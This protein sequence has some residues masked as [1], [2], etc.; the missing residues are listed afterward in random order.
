[1]RSG[2]TTPFFSFILMLSA[3]GAETRAQS[4]QGEAGLPP[5]LPSNREIALAESAGPKAVADAATLYVLERGGYRVARQGTNGFACLVGRERPETVEPMCFDPEGVE[6]VLPRIL[7]A[8]KLREEGLKDEDVRRKIA[9]GFEA[10]KYRAPKRAGVNYMLSRENRVFNGKTVVPYPPHV[11]I[12]APFV[13]N[14]DIGSTLENPWLP[15]VLGEGGPHAYI[16]VVVR[17][18]DGTAKAG[19]HQHR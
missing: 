13:S 10:G 1:M 3:F 12:Y 5:L 17:D 8:A 18:D 16:M 6:T 14:A 9:E 2:W 15:W 7:D 11:M 4:I 19:D